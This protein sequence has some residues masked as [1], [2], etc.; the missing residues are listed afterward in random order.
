MSS[1]GLKIIALISMLFDHCGYIF[2]NKI[3]FMNIIGKIAFPIF[4]FQISEGYLR[5]KNL[6][7]YFLRLFLFAI[8]SQIPFMLFL[9]C[10]GTTTIYLN[11]F[12][13]LFLGLLSITLYNKIQNKPFSL[14]LV[15]LIILLAK[16][17]HCDYGWYGVAIIFLFYLFKNNPLLMNITFI[18]LT[19]IK[20]IPFTKINIY[21]AISTCLS[22]IIINSYNGK[23]GRNMHYFLYFFYPFHLI[24]LSLIYN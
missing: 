1:F 22:L 17:T 14:V 2:F 18:I 9:N 4:A 24:I 11:I 20:Y 8:A 19:I 21:L 5:T 7:N 13:T 23:K 12:F 6:K 16:I 10:L 3:T 15:L